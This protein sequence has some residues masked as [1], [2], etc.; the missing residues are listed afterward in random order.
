M[1][2]FSIP[3][4]DAIIKAYTYYTGDVFGLWFYERSSDGAVQLGFN[5]TAKVQ[6]DF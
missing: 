2:C 4:Y 6:S 1:D 3:C 5:I